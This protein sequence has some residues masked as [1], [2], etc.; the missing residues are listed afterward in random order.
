MVRSL[1]HTQRRNAVLSATVHSYINNAEPVSSEGLAKE[2]SCS[3]ATIRSVFSQLEDEGYL[4]HTHISSG[5]IPTDRGY[6]YY[7]DFFTKQ[8]QILEDQ[9]RIVQEEYVNCLSRLDDLLDKTTHI[10]SSLTKNA[11]L[12][13]C[14]EFG[15]KLFFDGTSYVLEQ[16]EFKDVTRIKRL[17]KLLEE[18]HKLIDIINRD[19]ESKINIYIGNELCCPE[20][21]EC[22]LIVVSYSSK[23]MPKGRIAVLGPKR[24]HYPQLISAVSYIS[25]VLSNLLDEV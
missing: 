13:S 22:A 23:N 1:D 9:K 19:I 10:V 3:S 15:D 14:I 5:R 4:T 24:M 18:K 7:V 25:D 11:G 20:I 2:F 17:V 21:D 8:I 16:P 6:R 12:V